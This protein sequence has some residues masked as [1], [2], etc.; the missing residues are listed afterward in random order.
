MIGDVAVGNRRRI[1]GC[2]IRAAFAKAYNYAKG[3]VAQAGGP[4]ET[5]AN[6]LVG[7]QDLNLRPTDYESVVLTN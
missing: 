3:F 5:C 7:Q 4:S 1:I 6:A 2:W